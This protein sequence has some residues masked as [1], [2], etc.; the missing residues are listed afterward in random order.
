MVVTHRGQKTFQIPKIGY[1]NFEVYVQREINNILQSVK[2]WVHAYVDD[3][4]CKAKSLD[5]LFVKLRILV[6]IFVAYTI[7]IKLIKSFLNYPNV[8]LFGQRVDFL[9]LMTAEDKLQAIKL[10]AYPNMLEVLK[11]YLG[12]NG[13]L[14]SYIYFYAQL[15]KLF[16]T[17]KTSLLKGASVASQQRRAYVS[18]T[19]LGPITSWELAF[20]HGLQAALA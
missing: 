4:I 8:G 11:Y 17:F 5:N 19:K 15:A 3:I 2:D 20:F 12:L 10:L 1:I 18:K 9:G 6:K 13:Y 16:Q 7:L 14:R